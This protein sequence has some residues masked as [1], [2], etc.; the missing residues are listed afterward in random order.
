MQ[1]IITTIIYV[2]LKIVSN[3]KF[4]LTKDFIIWPYAHMSS[5]LGHELNCIFFLLPV[6]DNTQSVKFQLKVDFVVKLI[7]TVL[8]VLCPKINT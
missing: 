1:I 5:M 7:S 4:H 8:W 3:N 2:I 6:Y